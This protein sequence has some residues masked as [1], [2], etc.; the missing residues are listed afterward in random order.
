MLMN[1]MVKNATLESF[2]YLWFKSITTIS[3]ATHFFGHEFEQEYTQIKRIFE[4]NSIVGGSEKYNYVCMKCGFP[5]MFASISNR[6]FLWPN[7]NWPNPKAPPIQISN[8]TNNASLI[9]S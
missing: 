5:A 8:I 7:E 2:G 1:L 9:V 3:I 6:V 4:R